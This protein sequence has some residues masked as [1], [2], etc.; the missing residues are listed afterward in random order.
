MAL[1]DGESLFAAV[2]D[3]LVAHD[4]ESGRIRTVN[5]RYCELVGY[6]ESELRGMDIATLSP[7]ERP[8]TMATAGDFLDRARSEGPLC[9]ES[10]HDPRDGDPVPVAVRSTITTESGT[11]TVVASVHERSRQARRERTTAERYRTLFERM[12]IIC[13]EFDLSAAKR[14]IDELATQ[15]DDIAGR[16]DAEPVEL[17]AVFDRVEIRDVN[18]TAVEFYGASSKADLRA[19]FEDIMTEKSFDMWRELCAWMADGGTRYRTE[20]TARLFS[21]EVRDLLLETYC[22]TEASPDYS[23]VFTA[24]IDITQRNAYE[25]ALCRKNELLDEFASVV[26]HEIETPLGVVDNTA[27]LVERTGELSHLE[28]VYTTTDKIRD[29]VDD[30]QILARQGT[31]VTERADVEVAAAARAAWGAVESSCGSLQLDTTATVEADRTRLE[32]LLENLFVNSLQHG[33]D[34]SS[35]PRPTESDGG[36]TVSVGDLDDGFYVA[37]DGVGIPDEKREQVFEQGYTT[38][39]D[40]T[41]LGLAIVRQIVAGHDWDI[42]VSG[43]ESGGAR[44][45]I[46]TTGTGRID[47]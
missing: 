6:P 10:A 23:H 35:K 20:C 17:E 45:E 34:R 42:D 28:D 24:G 38:G 2:A 27:Q 47:P 32:R 22:M 13:F 1:A 19:N 15:T 33:L 44:F 12:P 9:F 5:D 16:L 21:G 30:L 40:S 14:Y 7:T 37:D 25:D 43:S 31:T 8:F 18:Q 29:I 39:D 26:A 4:L 36:I 41:G 46:R 11:E 3:G